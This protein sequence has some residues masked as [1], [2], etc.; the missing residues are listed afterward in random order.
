MFDGYLDIEY[1]TLKRRKLQG[2][3][4]LWFVGFLR[5]NSKIIESDFYDLK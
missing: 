3:Y 5:E 4:I 2:V 1:K